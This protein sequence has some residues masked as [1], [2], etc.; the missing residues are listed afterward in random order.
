M[1]YGVHLTIVVGGRRLFSHSLTTRSPLT[2]QCDVLL[3]RVQ[4]SSRQ[5][6]RR[7]VTSSGARDF[8]KM[9]SGVLLFAGL[10]TIGGSLELRNGAYEDLVVKISDNVPQRECTRILENLEA[11]LDTYRPVSSVLTLISTGQSQAS[12]LKT[13]D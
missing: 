11:T 12:S 2:S 8:A 4:F 3:V 1:H 6:R 5:R 10:L 13:A 9:I 7:L